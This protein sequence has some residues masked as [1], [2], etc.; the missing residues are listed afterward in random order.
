MPTE[1]ELLVRARDMRCD[2][3]E[4]EIRVWRHLSNSQTGY[5]FRRHHVILPYIC[6]FFCPAKGLIVEIDGDTRDPVAD[7]RR[8]AI[9]AKQG[10]ET[11]R[12]SN[13]DV[14]ENLEGVVLKIIAALKRRP[15]RWPDSPHPNPSPEGE[16]IETKS[17]PLPFRGGVGGEGHKRRHP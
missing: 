8:D 12:F 14:R 3:T 17:K 7:V 11:I 9:L 6:D 15:D 13:L 2:P 5:K 1:A 10:F 16:G 4:W